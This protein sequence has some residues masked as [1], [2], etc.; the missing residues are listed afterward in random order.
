MRHNSRSIVVIRSGFLLLY[1]LLPSIV[2]GSVESFISGPRGI[3]EIID[4]QGTAQK[5]TPEST[6]VRIPSGSRIRVLEGCDQGCRIFSGPVT[7]I[8]L[9]GREIEYTELPGTLFL[10]IKSV[11]GSTSVFAA[12][13]HI[14]IPE[15][16][17]ISVGVNSATM[18]VHIETLE[19]AATVTP[20]Q[21][22]A[23]VINAGQVFDSAGRTSGEVQNLAE[24]TKGN[25]AGEPAGKKNKKYFVIEDEPKEPE[26]PEASA[27]RP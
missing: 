16:S 13:I 4:G 6:M 10:R 1:V 5:I 21:G 9:P 14:Q 11:T 22:D 2:F 8:L 3:L 15:K 18:M 7:T 17:A 27:Y 12:G 19:G 26:V 24:D 25:P 23:A 20:L